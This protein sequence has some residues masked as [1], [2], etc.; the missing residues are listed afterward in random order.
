M[1]DRASQQSLPTTPDA[2]T[3][4]SPAES[5]QLSSEVLSPQE[6]HDVLHNAPTG[7]DQ[8]SLTNV[9][10]QALDVHARDDNIDLDLW[11]RHA[12]YPYL[13]KLVAGQPTYEIS[14]ITQ[15]A[16][17]HR[18]WIKDDLIRTGRA[19]LTLEFDES[20]RIKAQQQRRMAKTGLRRRLLDKFFIRRVR[21]YN[22]SQ[23]QPSLDDGGSV[24]SDGSDSSWD[25]ANSNSSQ[26]S[27]SAL[28]DVE[29][30]CAQLLRVFEDVHQRIGPSPGRGIIQEFRPQAGDL[31]SALKR[32]EHSLK[33]HQINAREIGFSNVGLVLNEC[34][35]NAE[36]DMFKILP[37][38]GIRR[39]RRKNRKE[40]DSGREDN[41]SAMEKIVTE[42]EKRVDAIMAQGKAVFDEF[43][44]KSLLFMDDVVR[45]AAQEANYNVIDV[46]EDKTLLKRRFLREK[47]KK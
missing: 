9:Q 39:R 22:A 29:Q 41:Y 11:H 33:V 24:R 4:E 44:G 47:N 32:L 5:Q 46:V 42:T 23:G 43:Y 35:E 28:N 20:K 45:S 40:M 7:Q 30:G 13:V 38:I 19:L 34:C 2:T 36:T 37:E 14:R 1:I 25:T 18:N 16:E 17:E 26:T 8:D 6:T 27:E 3:E 31:E 21:Q 12:C 15:N 10:L